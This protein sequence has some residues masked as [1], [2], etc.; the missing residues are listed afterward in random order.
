MKDSTTSHVYDGVMVMSSIVFDP[1]SAA[2]V[3]AYVKV[4]SAALAGA[5]ERIERAAAA[6]R[7]KRAFMAGGGEGVDGWKKSKGE[8]QGKE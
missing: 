7:E 4:K 8:K 3:G 6:R 2:D 1:W 5:R